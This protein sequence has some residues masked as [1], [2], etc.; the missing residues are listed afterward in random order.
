M[1]RCP[2]KHLSTRVPSSCVHCGPQTEGT[3]NGRG[4]DDKWGHVCTWNTSRPREGDVGAQYAW[5]GVTVC[6]WRQPVTKACIYAMFPVLG[7]TSLISQTGRLVVAWDGGRDRIRWMG[8]QETF[9]GNGNV[10]CSDSSGV[11]TTVYI[12]QNLVK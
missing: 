5:M 1:K 2:Y 6:V 7:K 4:M 9:C 11:Y 12:C 3:P 8:H 10:L